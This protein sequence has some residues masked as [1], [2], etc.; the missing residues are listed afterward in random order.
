M[1]IVNLK[2]RYY[3]IISFLIF[4]IFYVAYVTPKT[5]HI[6]E[7]E[8]DELDL[9]F[10]INSLIQFNKNIV[11]YTKQIELLKILNMKYERI[12]PVNINKSSV[13][14]NLKATMYDNN[15]IIN[16]IEWKPNE[17]NNTYISHPFEVRFTGQYSNSYKLIYD[18]FYK[19]NLAVSIDAIYYSRIESTNNLD[20]SINGT[21]YSYI[22]PMDR[23]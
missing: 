9:R 3:I 7:L 2:N 1:M 6:S 4:L 8:R 12:F 22:D 19:P 15:L 20:I 18:M 16:K 10:E 5:Q 13:E 17:F 14:D 23:S 11:E 21:Y